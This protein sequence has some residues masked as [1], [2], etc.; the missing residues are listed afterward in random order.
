MIFIGISFRLFRLRW[1]IWGG[2]D[3]DV[4]DIVYGPTNQNGAGI[5]L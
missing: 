1:Q 3:R 2:S 5:D 4:I